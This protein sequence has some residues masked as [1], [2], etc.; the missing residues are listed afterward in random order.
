[1]ATRKVSGSAARLYLAHDLRCGGLARDRQHGGSLGGSTIMDTQH[2]DP[3]ATLPMDVLG[4]LPVGVMLMDA[5][6][7]VVHE[8]DALRD[9]W[10]GLAHH[11]VDAPFPADAYS[12]D[13]TPLR[14]DDWPIAR[15]LATGD[16]IRDVAIELERADDDPVSIVAESR[17]LVDAGGRRV[18]AVMTVRDVSRQHDQAMLREAFV[19]ILSHELRTPVTSIYSGVELLRGHK[20]S[21]PV[22]RDVLHDVAVEAETLHRLIEDLL[23]M[24]RLERGVSM[25]LPEPVLVHRIVELAL[26]EERRRWPDHRFVAVIP[27]DLPIAQGDEGLLRQVLRNLLSNAAKYGR[28]AGTVTV[29]AAA[30]PNEITVAVSDE[31]PGIGDD[32]R[33]RVFDLFYRG[34]VDARIAGSGIGLFV[35]KA[36]MEAMDGSITIGRPERGAEF[37]LHLPRYGDRPEAEGP[38][39]AGRPTGRPTRSDGVRAD[40][41]GRPTAR[42]AK[43]PGRALPRPHQETGVS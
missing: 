38:V 13:G 14:P 20:L 1:M 37:I 35:A 43:S 41:P 4:Q 8:N 30:T 12:E 11:P 36:L 21:E 2:T 39:A 17:P 22:T 29:T 9:L 28:R 33:D 23:V 16:E 26:A 32:Q 27:S 5:A 25:A 18:G 42:R 15:S 3:A 31:G 24:V 6:G 19:G 10:G 34:A 7:T 40:R